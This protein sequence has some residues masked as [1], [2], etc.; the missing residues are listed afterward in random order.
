MINTS[1]VNGN[2]VHLRDCDAWGNSTD[3]VSSYHGIVVAGGISNFSIIGCKSGQGPRLT[4]NQGYGIL[5][6]SGASNNYIIAN[7]LLPG[8]NTG[9]MS[10]GGTGTNKSVSNNITW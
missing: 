7:N 10:D 8:N 2:G 1:G 9:G 4:D 6:A 5:V 3:G